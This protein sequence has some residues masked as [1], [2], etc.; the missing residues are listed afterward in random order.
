MQ[1]H[2]IGRYTFVRTYVRAARQVLGTRALTATF[3]GKTINYL[4][5]AERYID[6]LDP[7]NRSDRTGEFEEGSSY[8]FQNDL[9]RMK[10]AFGRLL[11]GDWPD[12][13]K[14]SEDY[15]PKPRAGYYGKRSVFEGGSA[16]GADD[17]D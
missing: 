6:Q 5:W 15:T 9:D 3:R 10:K 13:W 17:E 7:L 11:G 2:G 1:G 14:I 8:Q 12:A 4:D 16:N